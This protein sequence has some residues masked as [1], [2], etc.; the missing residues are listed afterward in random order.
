ML[1]AEITGRG[2]GS[3]DMRWPRP[4]EVKRRS[5]KRLLM[6]FFD[7]GGIEGICRRDKSYHI[8]AE[9][10]GPL[11]WIRLRLVKSKL[12]RRFKIGRINALGSESDAKVAQRLSTRKLLGAARAACSYA[13]L[14]SSRNGKS[15]KPQS[16]V[17]LTNLLSITTPLLISGRP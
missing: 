17:Q 13:R 7:Y 8:R 9:V 10:I 3:Y 12:C 4:K 11:L 6:G 16:Q 15:L 2:S 14:K 5:N 1:L